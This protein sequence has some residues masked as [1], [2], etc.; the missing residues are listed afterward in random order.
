MT[1]ITV[2]FSILMGGHPVTAETQE[3]FLSSMR[4][5]LLVFCGL[6]VVGIF[7]SIGRLKPREE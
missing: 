2:V 1:I 4:I 7:C 6:C 3:A 5:A